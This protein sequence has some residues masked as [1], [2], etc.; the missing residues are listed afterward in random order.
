[1]DIDSVMLQKNGESTTGLTHRYLLKPARSTNKYGNAIPLDVAIPVRSAQF[2]R[3]CLARQAI[4]K[5]RAIHTNRLS[6]SKCHRTPSTHNDVCD[7]EF[8]DAVV[9][10]AHLVRLDKP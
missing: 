1:M 4:P 10:E 5:R 6:R 7:D 9:A 8:G 3:D 2:L